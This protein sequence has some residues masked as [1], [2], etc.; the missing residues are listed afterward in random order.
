MRESN[1]GRAKIKLNAHCMSKKE[2]EK[3]VATHLGDI[4]LL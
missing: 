3:H 2:I 1:P 4:A